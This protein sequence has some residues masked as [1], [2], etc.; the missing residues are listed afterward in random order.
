LAVVE[1]VEIER[2]SKGFVAAL[3]V[4]AAFAPEE[5]ADVAVVAAAFAPEELADVAVVAAAV[6]AAFA[7][8][9]LADVAVVAV[10]VVAAFAPEEFA[11]KTLFRNINAIDFI[12]CIRVTLDAAF[13]ATAAGVELTYKRRSG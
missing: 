3:A 13:F 6:V 10:A 5:L 11:A 4:V 1:V 8:E 7:P 2:E 12:V 9:E